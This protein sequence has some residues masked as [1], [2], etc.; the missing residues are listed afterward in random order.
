VGLGRHAPGLHHALFVQAREQAGKE[1][2]PTAAIIDSQS[3]RGAE[4]GALASTRRATT[5]ARRSKARSGRHILVD[6]RGLLLSAAIHPASVRDRDRAVPL[7]RAARRPF[8]FVEVILAD[9]AYRGEATAEAVAGTGRRRL[10]VVRRGDGL[11]FVPLPK[12]WLVERTFA[13]LG[14]CRRLAKG[15]ES[16]AVNALAFLCL[17]MSCP[18]N[19][20][21]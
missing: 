1:A 18:L 9:G 8:P 21:V 20:L 2:S 4:K 19:L 17:G 16:L 11:G 15:F 14:R 7:L 5:R 10:E 13:W 6:T 12:R 3:V